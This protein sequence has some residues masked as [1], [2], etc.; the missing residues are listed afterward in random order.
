MKEKNICIPATAVTTQYC[1]VDDDDNENETKS[2][3][4]EHSQ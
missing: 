2:G 1:D 4:T 3:C